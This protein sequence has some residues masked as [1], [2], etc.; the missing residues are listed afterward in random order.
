[1]GKGGIVINVCQQ[2]SMFLINVYNTYQRIFN[3]SKLP[4]KDRSF[5]NGSWR[6]KIKL[7]HFKVPDFLRE[8]NRKRE[9]SVN[10][11]SLIGEFPRRCSYG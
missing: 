8:L 4:K 1:M 10:S 6:L 9:V 11:L 2:F 5:G 3:R 7:L